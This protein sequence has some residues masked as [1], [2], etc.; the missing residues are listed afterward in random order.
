M[1]VAQKFIKTLVEK[2]GK[3]SVY[4]DGDTWYEAACYVLRLKHY[5]QLNISD[6]SDGKSQPI[7]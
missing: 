6:E 2:Y 7:V 4:T 1:L 3:Q 5:I